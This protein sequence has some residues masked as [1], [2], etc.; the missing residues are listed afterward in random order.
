MTDGD[1]NWP[2]DLSKGHGI[3]VPLEWPQVWSNEREQ[4]IRCCHLPSEHNLAKGGDGIKRIFC[5]SCPQ[6][7]TMLMGD[8]GLDGPVP[9]FIEGPLSKRPCFEERQSAGGDD[10][11][12]PLS[13]STQGIVTFTLTATTPEGEEDCSFTWTGLS[14]FPDDFER[15]VDG[16]RVDKNSREFKLHLYWLQEGRCVGC[17]RV[18][19]FDHM[20]VD[21]I[22]PGTAGPGY[23]VGNVQLLCSSCNKI[24]GER[25]MEYL[26]TRLS[27][28]G[29]PR[30]FCQD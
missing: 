5:R 11:F 12:L 14:W 26:T 4:C 10:N 17:Q 19:Y 3:Y 2:S 21:R 15:L 6:T 20:E 28:R 30:V 1:S 7:R 24:K 29:L 27:E 23:T 9:Y 25:G 13:P 8:E 18:I 22:V 16:D